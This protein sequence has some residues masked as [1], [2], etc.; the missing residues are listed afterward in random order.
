[1]RPRR[2]HRG[3]RPDRPAHTR[4]SRTSR[5][6]AAPNIARA[7]PSIARTAL[8]AHAHNASSAGRL[9]TSRTRPGRHTNDA[10]CFT[11]IHSRGRH[12]GE[13]LGRARGRALQG[14]HPI[15][16]SHTVCITYPLLLL[17]PP[18]FRPRRTLSSPSSLLLLSSTCRAR[19]GQPPRRRAS[20][21]ATLSSP[22]PS[23]ALR[24]A[25]LDFAAH[26][27]CQLQ[28]GQG[29]HASWGLARGGVSDI[30]SRRRGW[31]ASS[32]TS[33]CLVRTRGQAAYIDRLYPSVLS[34][35]SRCLTTA[36]P[37]KAAPVPE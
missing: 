8:I 13:P 26:R 19:L 29:E 3:H 25:H 32:R 7:A 16:S 17:V 23:T 5:A 35:R 6:P 34:I 21:V 9:S 31:R 22:P 10:P 20:L 24:Y 11:V 14:T 2:R 30:G 36:C 28:G 27:C 37:R 15:G 18:F 33:A 1:M 4:A 12:G